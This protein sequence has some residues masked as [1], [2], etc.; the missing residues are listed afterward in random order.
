MA[1]NTT[2][3]GQMTQLISRLE[4]QSI[5]KMHKGDHKVTKLRCWDQFIHGLLAQVSG[6]HSLRETVSS[7]SLLGNKLYHLGSQPV[8]VPLF[9]TPITNVH[10]IFTKSSFSAS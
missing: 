4:F 1:Y 9:P 10:L 8:S 7:F 2:I 3:I 5:V 6:R